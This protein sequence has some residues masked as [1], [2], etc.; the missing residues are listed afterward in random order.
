[1]I[2]FDPFIRLADWL[3]DEAETAATSR[4]AEGAGSIKGVPAT[5]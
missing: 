4:A 3:E 2:G 1:V 5:A